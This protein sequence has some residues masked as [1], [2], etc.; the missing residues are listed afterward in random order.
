MLLL[1][2]RLLQR[3]LHAGELA[4]G[5]ADLVGAVFRPMMRPGS[6]G[7]WEK[8]SIEL[9]IARIGRIMMRSMAV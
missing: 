7:A 2:E 1:A 5:D 8:A 3:A 9:V 4:L 6:S